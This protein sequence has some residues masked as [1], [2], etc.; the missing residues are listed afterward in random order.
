MATPFASQFITRLQ[1]LVDE[2]G[3]LPIQVIDADT[4][5]MLDPGLIG[6]RPGFYPQGFEITTEYD[7]DPEGSF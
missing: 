1:A 2:H 3:D 6:P 7:N 5:W 4:G